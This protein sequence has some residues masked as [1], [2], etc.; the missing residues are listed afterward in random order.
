M[1]TIKILIAIN[2]SKSKI[3]NILEYINLQKDYNIEFKLVTNTYDSANHILNNGFH[4]IILDSKLQ[5]NHRISLNDLK[6][7]AN[8]S[9][10]SIIMLDTIKEKLCNKDDINLQEY[11][12]EKKTQIIESK[13]IKSTNKIKNAKSSI[14]FKSMAII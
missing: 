3:A 10:K 12:L 11:L 6:K 1:E 2:P 4:L 7:L 9:I 13:I 8:S 5:V 14:F